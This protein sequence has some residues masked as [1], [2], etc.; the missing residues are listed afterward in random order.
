MYTPTHVIHSHKDA[1]G[2][3]T[4]LKYFYIQNLEYNR[5]TDHV[6][7]SMTVDINKETIEKVFFIKKKH[8]NEKEDEDE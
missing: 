7:G 3:V 5:S 1:I 4:R 2:K 8:S 6:C